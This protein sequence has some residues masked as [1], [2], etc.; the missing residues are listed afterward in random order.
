VERLA[1]EQLSDEMDQHDVVA[2]YNLDY[3]S[4]SC[5]GDGNRDGVVDQ[6]DLDNWTELSQLNGGQSS[7]Y[8]FNHDGKTDEADQL[9]IQNNIG[10]T[11]SAS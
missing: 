8:D 7:W 10:N 6:R 2:S 1:Y 4:V 9:I 5:P 11:C 3:D